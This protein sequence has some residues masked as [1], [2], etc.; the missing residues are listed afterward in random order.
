ML[1]VILMILA[2]AAGSLEPM[3]IARV[4][5]SPLLAAWHVDRDTQRTK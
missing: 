4:A 5:Q 1:L 2:L 3:R